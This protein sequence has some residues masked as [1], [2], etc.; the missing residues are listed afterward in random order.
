VRGRR[1]R[2][3][4]AASA[5]FTLI[6]LLVVMAVIGLLLAA[7]APRYVQ[8]VDQAREVT[9]RHNLAAIRDAIDKFQAD[10]G[11]HP[12]DLQE[13]VLQRYLRELPLDPVT[14]RVDTW[15]PLAPTGQ[16][17]G[18]GLA[19]VHSGASGTGRDGRPYATW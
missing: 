17:G 1:H 16:G 8:H 10:R 19:D 3:S 2:H 11:R 15:V 4:L 13:L 7:V 18:S 9:L 5:G 6:E 14:D 12:A